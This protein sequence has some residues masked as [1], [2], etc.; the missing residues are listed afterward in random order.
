MQLR[1]H[2]AHD[3]LGLVQLQRRGARR[4]SV[5]ALPCVRCTDAPRLFLDRVAGRKYVAGPNAYATVEPIREESL[6]NVTRVL[7]NESHE[8]ERH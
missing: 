5:V 3:R 8:G 1:V 6:P 2:P 7:Q 4:A